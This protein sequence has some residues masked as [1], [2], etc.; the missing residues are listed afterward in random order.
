LLFE[1]WRPRWRLY[2]NGVDHRSLDGGELANLLRLP[3]SL[4]NSPAIN[5]W[6]AMIGPFLLAKKLDPLAATI[7]YA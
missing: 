4:A 1:C 3:P 7:A 5:S 6:W 2:V